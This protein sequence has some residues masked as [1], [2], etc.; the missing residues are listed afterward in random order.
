MWLL[1]DPLGLSSL[2]LV[3]P[4]AL[5]QLLPFC[6]GSR[7]VAEIHRDFSGHLGVPVALHIVED[8]LAQLDEAYLL[9]NK[10]SVEAQRDHLVAYRA[11]A[12]RP[13]ALA[14]HGYPA[15]A[16]ALSQ[17]LDAYGEDCEEA[18]EPWYGRAILSPH[19]DYPRGGS[20]YAK[21]WRRAA[22][23]V[24]A[25]DLIVILGTDHTGDQPITLTTQPYATPYGLLPTDR[26][27][28]DALAA[29]IGRADAFAD[30][31]NHRHEHSVEL[32]AVWAHYTLNGQ[33]PPP[34]IPILV[35]SF[36]HHLHEN[37]H[38]A[39]DPILNR[40]LDALHG[41][42]RDHR[43]LAVASVDLAHVG[44]AFGDAWHMTARR[45]QALASRDEA[46]L[47]A[48]TSGDPD[49][50]YADIA[51]INDRDRICGF[52]PIYLLLR[53]LGKTRGETVAYAQCAA[54]PQNRSLV[55][56]CGVLLD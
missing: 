54:D 56:I 15:E 55:S 28:V 5:A 8:T 18:A 45:R 27:I 40:F 14:G 6:D 41:I 47:A 32:S 11:Q 13:A 33:P 46:R 3:L 12:Q 37:S 36:G 51:A 9:E 16:S 17:A 48:V 34:T 38:P 43:V 52:A 42:T 39:D 53:Y 10:R 19:I 7:T 2:Q 24:A 21:V 26:G 1:R 44:P 30:E 29:A 50:F 22:A 23:A 25:S 31:L 20:V 4:A 49:R 35:G